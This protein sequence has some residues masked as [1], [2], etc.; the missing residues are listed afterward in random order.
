MSVKSEV[1]CTFTMT[2][3]K[4]LV[5]VLAHVIGQAEGTASSV[6]G[7]DELCRKDSAARWRELKAYVEARVSDTEKKAVKP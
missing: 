7:I 3:A 4:S 6:Y 1:Y 5:R 2:G